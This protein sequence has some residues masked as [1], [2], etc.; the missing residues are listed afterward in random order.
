MAFKPEIDTYRLFPSLLLVANGKSD[1][2]PVDNNAHSILYTGDAKRYRHAVYA[3]DTRRRIPQALGSPNRDSSLI[4]LKPKMRSCQ[5]GGIPV[6][7][8]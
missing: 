2:I 3:R 7:R 5:K 8:N 1:R 4:L 6:A